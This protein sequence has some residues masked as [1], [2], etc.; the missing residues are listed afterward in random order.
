MNETPVGGRLRPVI[1]LELNELAPP[2]IERFIA[3][4][5]LPQF[6]RLRAES[7][8]FVTDA[9]ETQGHLNPWIQWVTAH[10]GLSYA[11][12]GVF[13]LGEGAQLDAPTVADEVGRAGGEVWLCGPM[14][15]VPNEPVVGMYLPDPWSPDPVP[16]PAELAPFASFVRANVQE[17]TNA[18]HRLGPRD[19][20]RFGAFMVRHGLSPR[21]AWRTARQLGGERVNKVPRW[22]RAAL[23]DQFQWDVFEHYY[24]RRRPTF[25]TLFSNTT[26]HFQHLYWRH[27]DPDPFTLKPSDEERA[28]YGD[29]VR[30][31][32]TEMDE[33]VGRA[34]DLA[35]EFGA[36]LVFATAISQQP[37]VLA[38]EGDGSRFHRPHDLDDFVE[39]VGLRGVVK[40]TPVMAGQF[41]LFFESEAAATAGLELLDGARVAGRPLMTSRRNGTDVLTGCAILDA[42]A[43]DAVAEFP[44]SARREPFG[45]LFYRADVAKSGWH[46]PHGLFWVRGQGVPTGARAGTVPLRS[47][48]PTLL[49]LV[50]VAAPES[51]TAASLLA[52]E[53]A[54]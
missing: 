27:M 33:L 32:Y 26:A 30:F 8:T 38:E 50:G 46:H 37:Y 51:M 36:I 40:A 29:A 3:D 53:L 17:H 21:T 14:N 18:R 9:E 39:R 41:H 22:Q 12:H 1:V 35:D 25:A 7:A 42:V 43:D 2:L 6:A 54:R 49:D 15:V 10:T 5:S 45:A 44:A 31:G 28:T 20:A 19:I 11:E 16:Q 52:P 13:K 47:V 48:A 4:G 34:I 23:L 24:R